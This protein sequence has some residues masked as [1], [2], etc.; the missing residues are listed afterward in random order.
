MS[1]VSFLS[2][3]NG[4]NAISP[5]E[6]GRIV[7][8]VEE[9]SYEEGDYLIRRGE[10]GD[11]MH[12]IVTGKVAVP[13]LDGEGHPKMVV[14][15]GPSDL[16]GE[17]ALLTGERRSADVIAEEPVT[18]LM[19]SRDTLQP[20]LRAHPPLARFLTEILGQR[21]EQ[22]QISRVGKYRLLGK[23]GEG[24]TAKVYEGIH[25]ALNRLVAIKM[26]SHSL[27]FDS[28]FQ[29]R[30]LQ[31]ARTIAGLTHP[32]IVQIFDTESA[33]ATYFIVMEKVDGTDLAKMLAARRTIPPAECMD[34]LCQMSAALSHAHGQGIVHRDVKPANTAVSKSGNV[35]LMDFGIA[36]PIPKTPSA[37]RAKTV[38]GTPRYLAPEAAVGK[39]VDGRADIYSLGIMAYEMVTGRVP[40]YADTIRELL[41][42]HVRKA[43]VDVAKLQPGIPSGLR[44]FIMG[45]LI[46]RPDERLSDWK[47]IQELLGA[48]RKTGPVASLRTDLVAEVLNVAYPPAAADEVSEVLSRFSDELLGV[49]GVALQRAVLRPVLDDFLTGAAQDMDADPRP[50]S[51]SGDTRAMGTT[52]VD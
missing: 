18:T 49:D 31:E 48:G 34:I 15:L 30:F 20:L 14:H 37:Q 7:E 5:D 9:R 23:L 38:E 43:P 1:T 33:Y 11:S 45:A 41:Q 3:V 47:R 52:M 50:S 21:L 46:K 51:G 19:L 6:L 25:P 27:L 22:S 35:K 42:M 44:E 17:M 4:F 40:F 28:S 2:Q 26:L 8:Q 24:A 36:K 13:I 32:N 10:E 29:E 16:V 39:V 12:V